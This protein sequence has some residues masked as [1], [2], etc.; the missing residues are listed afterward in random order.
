MFGARKRLRWKVLMGVVG[1][2]TLLAGCGDSTARH[3]EGLSSDEYQDH[4]KAL[5]E[6]GPEAIPLLRKVAEKT[7][8]DDPTRGRVAFTLS[9]LGSE[10]VEALLEI[11]AESDWVTIEILQLG[12]MPD[13]ALPYITE[14]FVAASKAH[15]VAMVRAFVEVC[16][17]NEQ[18][19]QRA[20]AEAAILIGLFI[21][22]MEEMGEP[23]SYALQRLEPSTRDT[24]AKAW[25]EIADS[26]DSASR[27]ASAGSQ[28]E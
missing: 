9:H 18:L 8:E 24:I 22:E 28:P 12:A 1:L 2:A 6:I 19:D 20:A 3:V 13:E 15:R 27:A 17:R 10:G 26:I 23:F 21:G 16:H 11:A 25:Q 7:P 5:K 4:A 14:H